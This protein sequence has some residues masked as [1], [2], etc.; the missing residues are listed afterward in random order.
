MLDALES[1]SR[2]A[3]ERSGPRSVGTPA[4]DVADYKTIGFYVG[5]QCGAS[6]AIHEWIRRHIGQC[7]V[8]TKDTLLCNALL[9][10][11]CDRFPDANVNDYYRAVPTTRNERIVSIEGYGDVTDY[12][13]ENVRYVIVDDANTLLNLGRLKRNELNQWVADN[14][15]P[16]TFV[17]LVK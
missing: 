8:I 10:Q 11:Y 3:W 13:R 7:L 16:D 9:Q 14:F 12:M 17:I 1:I 6:W 15:H 5:R 4:W 2:K